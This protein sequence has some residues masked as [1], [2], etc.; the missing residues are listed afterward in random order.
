MYFVFG[1]DGDLRPPQ[2]IYPTQDSFCGEGG[3]LEA[4]SAVINNL[5]PEKGLASQG[6]DAMGGLRFRQVTLAAGESYFYVVLMG[7]AEDEK[8]IANCLRRFRGRDKIQASFQ[9]TKESW[10]K[11]A[12]RISVSSGEADFDN[13]FRWVSIQPELRRIFGCSFLPDFDYGKGGRG[14]RD[15]WQDCLGL[16]LSEPQ[17]VRPLLL[18][19]F[20]G[21]RID[22]SNATIIGKKPGEFISDRNNISRVWMDHGIWPLLTLDL[23]I[24]ETGD[25]D[26]L[27]EEVGYFR[28]HQLSRSVQIDPDWRPACGRQLLTAKGKI[29][30]GTILEH[31]LV[32]NLVQFFNVGAHNF[33]R[34]EGADWNDALDMAKENGESVAFSSMY[35]HNLELLAK[36]LLGFG[37]K[38]IKLAREIKHLFGKINYNNAAL[39]RRILEDYFN[40]TNPV[41]GAKIDFDACAIA[42]DLKEKASWMR[43]Y[44]RS[45]AWQRQGFYNGYYDNRKKPVDGIKKG[46]VR[47]M[48]ASQ[49]FPIMGG[50]AEPEQITRMLKSIDRYLLDKKLKGFR[51]NT[52]FKEDLPV[53]GRAF[54]FIYG[55]KENGAVFNHMV[56]MFAY[57]LYKR[58]FINE[59]WRVLKSVY[60]MVGSARS[61]IYPCL[62]EYFN[63]EGRGMYSYL[64]GSASWFVLTLLTEVFGIKGNDGDL[65]IEPKLCPGQFAKT[66]VFSV[67]RIFAGR[68]LR[69]NFLRERGGYRGPCRIIKASLNGIDLTVKDPKTLAISRRLVLRLPA[70]D[71]STFDILVRI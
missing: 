42:A 47:M 19:N 40:K 29:Y 34:L 31:L 38:K 71:E 23:Y 35:A 51:L 53:L 1:W 36:I 58:G 59:G 6:K 44:I 45:R 33:V 24:N 50:V 60:D 46:R 66:N 37:H 27:F 39:K 65:L 18:N 61:K 54:S 15:L 7:I 69:V 28:D 22:G 20:S 57:G 25:T 9:N 10:L 14:W 55:E 26:I 12:E 70:A 30:K 13:W 52:D 16:I 64:T 49:V 48:L 62:P 56:V 11:Q 41:S 43:R 8:E 3:D 4:P 2:Y 5:P 67:T 17:K 21:V 63:N 68:K 32:Q